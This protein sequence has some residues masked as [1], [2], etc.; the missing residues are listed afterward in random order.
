MY[1]IGNLEGVHL[2]R[3]GQHDEWVDSILHNTKLFLF[4]FSYHLFCIWID[5]CKFVV[6]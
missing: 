2:Y 4:I 5:L 6:V 1:K 3:T